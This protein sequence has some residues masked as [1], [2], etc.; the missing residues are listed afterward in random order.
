MPKNFSPLFLYFCLLSL[1]IISSVRLFRRSREP[2]NVWLFAPRTVR[3][4]VMMAHPWQAGSL[5]KRISPWSSLLFNPPTSWSSTARSLLV[6]QGGEKLPLCLK[7]SVSQLVH[8]DLLYDLNVTF[9]RETHTHFPISGFNVWN[10]WHAL[11]V[12]TKV[13][14]FH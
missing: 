3:A 14:G 4:K 11:S 6:P 13:F 12:P 1:S 5:S 2:G 7:Y 10:L 9:N 8:F